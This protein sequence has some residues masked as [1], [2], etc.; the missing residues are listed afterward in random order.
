M[1]CLATP[2]RFLPLG[3]AELNLESCLPSG[4]S[5]RW[6][7]LTPPSA[8]LPD[9][10]PGSSAPATAEL[11]HSHEWAFGCGDRTLVL[12]QDGA[13]PCPPCTAPAST[14]LTP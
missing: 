5:F 1:S 9:S 6:H 10:T 4:Q 11:L 12:R 2:L 14:E 13:L 7:R 3:R 8:T